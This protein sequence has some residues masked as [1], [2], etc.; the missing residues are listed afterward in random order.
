MPLSTNYR[1][2]SLDEIIGNQSL[3]SSLY[4][5]IEREDRPHTYLFLGERGTGKTTL[6][7]VLANEFGIDPSEIKE[8][9]VADATGVD[10]ARNVIENA[11]YRPLIGTSKAFIFDEC[12]RA[13]GNFFDALLKI[14]E[15]PPK[16]CYFFFCTTEDKK[17]PKTIKSRCIEYRTS[18]FSDK[19]MELLLSN[20]LKSEGVDD[21][22]KEAIKEITSQAGGSARDALTI[23]EKVIDLTDEE[24]ILELKNIKEVEKQTIDLCRNIIKKAKWTDINKI[25]SGLTKQ[26]PEK[27][28]RAVLGYCSS[29]LLKNDNK[30]AAIILEEFSNPFYDSGFP[31][32]V[33]ACYRS[34]M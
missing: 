22:P 29:V 13:S 21:F 7:R 11:R 14:T 4:S 3:V 15:E 19:E 23:L 20:V 12:H 8:L 10:A 25:L 33:L 9:N 1:P 28:R 32:L 17:I 24:A 18:L 34:V 16:H 2:K 30:Q 5:I 26:E 27:I 31:G 6:S